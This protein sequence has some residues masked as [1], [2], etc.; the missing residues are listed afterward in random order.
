M[1]GGRSQSVSAFQAAADQ[2]IFRSSS[3]CSVTMPKPSS[4][5]KPGRFSHGGMIEIE[6]DGALIRVSSRADKRR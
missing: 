4:E 5:E 6:I 2:P 1:S 3:F